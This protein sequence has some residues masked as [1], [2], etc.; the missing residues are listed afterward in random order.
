MK[1]NIE[2]FKKENTSRII[3]AE[4]LRAIALVLLYGLALIGSW[5]LGGLFLWEISLSGIIILLVLLLH[6]EKNTTSYN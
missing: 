2:I 3:E 5:S 4:S 1:T 6:K